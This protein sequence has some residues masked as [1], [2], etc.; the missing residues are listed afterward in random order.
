MKR[1]KITCVPDATKQ[2]LLEWVTLLRFRKMLP[3][4]DATGT[5]RAGH[6]ALRERRSELEQIF[7]H[8]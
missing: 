4:F 2:F 7:K 8:F 1:A 5:V 3:I 6:G